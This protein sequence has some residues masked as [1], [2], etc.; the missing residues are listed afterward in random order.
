MRYE[1]F[2]DYLQDLTNQLCEQEGQDLIWYHLEREDPEAGKLVVVSLCDRTGFITHLS[3]LLQIINNGEELYLIAH[4]N[5]I[6][7]FIVQIT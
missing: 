1:V 5:N 4:Y 7:N 6:P 2:K 3:F